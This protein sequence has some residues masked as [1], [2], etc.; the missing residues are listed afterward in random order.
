MATW[1]IHFRVADCFL[2]RFSDKAGDE[3]LIGSVAPDCGYG[4]KDSF[5]GFM[6]PA[7]VTHWTQSGRKNEID[8]D[9]F[10]EA[11]LKGADAW[12]A[13]A[14]YLGYFVHLLTDMKWSS[15]MYL[16]TRIIYHDEYEK[17]PG[18]LL[19]I[20]EDWNDLDHKFLMENPDFRAYNR[21]KKITE[22][23]DYLPYYEPGQLKKQC[24]VIVDYYESFSDIARLGR[25]YTY[26]TQKRQDEFV[27][28]IYRS[29]KRFLKAVGILEE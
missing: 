13:A 5:T 14:F 18:F 7:T 21:F 4:R 23:K 20:K 19:K 28:E 25:E 2:D 1:M 27:G 9:A 22:I 12:G 24:G 3:F 17:D 29:V 16:P 8:I 15:E 6:P 10:F 26:L 11:Y